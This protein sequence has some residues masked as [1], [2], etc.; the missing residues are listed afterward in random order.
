MEHAAEGQPRLRN[1]SKKIRDLVAARDIGLRDRHIHTTF[2]QVVDRELRRC[3]RFVACD[4][5]Q[6]SRAAV[7]QP[8]RQTTTERARSAADQGTSHHCGTAAGRTVRSASA[9]QPR[10]VTLAIA[11]R[12]LLLA[13]RR[14]DFTQKHSGVHR[15][16]PMI[17]I[18]I[19]Q[20]TQPIRMLETEHTSDS[21]QRCLA[22]GDAIR[23]GA[24]ERLRAARHQP[25]PWTRGPLQISDR[26]ND[27]K[28]A[29]A[30]ARQI[31]VERGD[32]LH[33]R[34]PSIERPQVYNRQACRARRSRRPEHRLKVVT[35]QR[36][37]FHVKGAISANRV[38]AIRTTARP[39]R[40]C[41]S[42][43]SAV[44]TPESSA[45]MITSAGAPAALA[46]WG[47]RRH[48][49][50]GRPFSWIS[51]RAAQH[52]AAAGVLEAHRACLGDTTTLFVIET[53][54]DRVLRTH[55]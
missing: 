28:C 4:E 17:G 52:L 20:A 13:R 19:D 44:P 22:D 9:A 16:V 47:S 24:V 7:G 38:P 36:L 30:G 14:V 40:S 3:R 8:G 2:A 53:H 42:R 48:S 43:A 46:S 51:D 37:H 26:L 34:I 11:E 35:I 29:S 1:G 55:S 23:Q 33:T 25:E 39:P 32:A 45:R 15:C 49:T 5:H 27:V 54:I 10:D 41:T 6:V 12:D 31:G 21:P 50:R 18:E